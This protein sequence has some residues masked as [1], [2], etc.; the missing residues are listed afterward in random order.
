MRIVK[1]RVLKPIRLWLSDG[2]RKLAVA[3]GEPTGRRPWCV[4]VYDLHTGDTPAGLGGGLSGRLIDGFDDQGRLRV[5]PAKAFPLNLGGMACTE[6]IRTPRPW[7]VEPDRVVR[8]AASPVVLSSD[9][10]RCVA[11][12]GFTLRLFVKRA[13]GE[14]A[15][16]WQREV[17]NRATGSIRFLRNDSRFTLV[18][19][20]YPRK[21]RPFTRHSLLVWDVR[22]GREVGRT[23]PTRR[24]FSHLVPVGRQLVV[25]RNDASG[26]LPAGEVLAYDADQLDRGPREVLA[27][28]SPI[29]AVCADPL[30]RF[31]LTATAKLVT[32][33]DPATWLPVR[34]FNWKIG[35]ITCLT[36][37][38][39]GT[40]AAAG[41]HQGKVAVWDVE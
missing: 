3:N 12:V 41:G 31:V 38:P 23:E 37:S 34:T 9:G 8:T 40:V 26:I 30:G 6:A 16:K 33:W 4:D 27:S 1:C 25:G 7:D 28:Q 17:R 5:I 32:Q 22:T 35:T 13:N 29:A 21:G 39:D 24:P 14:W 11:A 10:S 18:E 2:G 20:E 36:V 19:S 15:E